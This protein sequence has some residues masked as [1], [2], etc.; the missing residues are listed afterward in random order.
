MTNAEILNFIKRVTCKKF[1]MLTLEAYFR[2]PENEI[3]SACS[4]CGC[5]EGHPLFISEA[6]EEEILRSD[7]LGFQVYWVEEDTFLEFE[8]LGKAMKKLNKNMKRKKRELAQFEQM[9]RDFDK[10]EEKC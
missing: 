8:S 6:T 1:Q 3:I 4:W 10:K 7:F 9:R 2:H 5:E